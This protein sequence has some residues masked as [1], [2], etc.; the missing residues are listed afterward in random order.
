MSEDLL[1]LSV[2]ELLKLYKAKKASPVDAAKESLKQALKYNPIFNALCF[3]DEKATLHQAKASEKRWMNGESKGPLDGVTVT[4]KDWFH[5]KGWP[6]RQGSKTTSALPQQS[7][8][9]PVARLKDAG[10]I[11]IGKTTLPE[12]GHKGVTDSPLTGITRNPWNLQ[13]TCG[14]SSGGAAVAAATG[15]AHLNLGSDAGGSIRIPASFTGVFGFKPSPGLVPSWPPSLFSTL[16]SAGPLTKCADDAAA[17]LDVLAQPDLRDW[18][19]SSAAKTDFSSVIDKPLPKLKIAVAH[20][21]NATSVQQDVLAVF[22]EKIKHLEA[23]GTVEIIDLKIPLLVD[24]FNSHWMAVA[25]YMASDYTTKQKRDMDPRFLHWASRGDALHLRDYLQAEYDRM[26]IGSTFKMLL[27]DY[28]LIVTPTTAMAAFDCGMNM[29]NDAKGKAWEDWTPF[30]YPANL[31]KLPAVSLPCG[32]TKNG[33]PVGMQVMSGYRRDVLLMQAAK[34]L[35]KEFA[36]APWLTSPS[37][38]SS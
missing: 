36:F 22:E 30:T 38:A 5:V 25:S 1:R 26:I 12:F 37:P 4:I 31:A 32:M 13:K 18:N 9:L 14:G 2:P 21:I 35:E 6:T 28:D 17:M 11:F 20:G 7:D 3:M 33:L 24:T 8:S 19:S 15:M 29:P 27:A 23:L 34:W 10:C 16:S